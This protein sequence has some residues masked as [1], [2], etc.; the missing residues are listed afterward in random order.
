MNPI[1][2]RLV[3]D[4]SLLL[5]NGKFKVFLVGTKN[6]GEHVNCQIIF[7]GLELGVF[8]FKA[9]YSNLVTVVCDIFN[10]SLKHCPTNK[11]PSYIL[12]TYTH[13]K[14]GTR[15]ILK[16]VINDDWLNPLFITRIDFYLATCI[17][18]SEL[19]ITSKNEP[20]R[21]CENGYC[22][23]SSRYIFNL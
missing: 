5:C 8:S 3:A 9:D 4:I 1:I 12:N 13:K 2:N 14:R 21:L 15:H 22:L 10:K 20:S 16:P 18:K 11:L 17:R 7:E 6:N 23:E 19:L